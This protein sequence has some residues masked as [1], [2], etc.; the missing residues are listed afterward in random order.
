LAEVEKIQADLGAAGMTPNL[1]LERAE[2]AAA[3]EQV[4]AQRERRD[5]EYLQLDQPSLAALADGELVAA[6]LARAR[7]RIGSAWSHPKSKMSPPMWNVWV[8]FFLDADVKNGGFDQY[9][10]NS[11]G[12]FVDDAIAAFRAMNA[13]AHADIAERAAA[14]VR[15]KYPDGKI[16]GHARDQ[17]LSPLDDEF[18]AIYPRG[19]ERREQNLTLLVLAPYAR[20]HLA[21]M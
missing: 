7:D 17:A 21:A 9:F 3:R 15:A 6:V 1:A 13:S 10:R 20:A 18:F 4:R 16:G 2:K 11:C 8:T 5:K 12:V 19:R 14:I